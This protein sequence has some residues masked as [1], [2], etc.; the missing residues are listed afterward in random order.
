MRGWEGRVLFHLVS[1]SFANF[2]GRGVVVFVVVLVVGCLVFVSSVCFSRFSRGLLHSIRFSSPLGFPVVDRPCLVLAR[3]CRKTKK[4]KESTTL[5]EGP[6]A[7]GAKCKRDS[8]FL[9]LVS[10]NFRP[11]VHSWKD[12]LLTLFWWFCLGFSGGFVWLAC[13]CFEGI[14]QLSEFSHKIFYPVQ[15]KRCLVG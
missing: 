5:Q 6:F 2:P 14:S 8:C 3:Q 1:L 9:F 4:S 10:C 11:V 12:A 7:E 13:G 15:A